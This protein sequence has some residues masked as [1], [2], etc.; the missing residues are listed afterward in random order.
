MS[1]LL[2]FLPLVG[3]LLDRILPDKAAAASA[4][5]ALLEL[6]QKGNLAQLDA[7]LH[8]A[9]GQLDINRAEAANSALFVSGW[10]PFIGWTCGAAY[11]YKFV[12][13]PVFSFGFTAA[14]HPLT[15]PVLDFSEM[16]PVLFG[17]LGLGAYR[18][19]EKVRGVA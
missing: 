1:A 18:T 2:D 17:L 16:M 14:G 19:Y 8:L 11:A 5:L 7:D 13:A 10:R 3:A 12:L 15:I 9:A 6:A 4:K